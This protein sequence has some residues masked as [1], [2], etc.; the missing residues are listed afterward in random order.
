MRRDIYGP[1]L[2]DRLK[3]Q[4][5]QEACGKIVIN[6]EASGKDEQVSEDHGRGYECP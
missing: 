5:S 6:L 1:R 2:K 4:G 3:A